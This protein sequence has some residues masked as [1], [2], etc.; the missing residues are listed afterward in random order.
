MNLFR[1]HHHLSLIP[2]FVWLMAQLTLTCSPLSHAHGP[3]DATT[4]ADIANTVHSHD[5]SANIALDGAEPED[6]PHHNHLSGCKWCQHFTSPEDLILSGDNWSISN[7]AD[8]KQ[9]WADA[10]HLVRLKIAV[11]G[12]SSRA[13]PV[14]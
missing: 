12:F 2:A 4:K 9:R 14:S 1:K 6:P 11:T 5:H 13:P 10:I 7:I 8:V 3:V